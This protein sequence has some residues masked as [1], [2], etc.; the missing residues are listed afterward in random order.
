MRT[1]ASKTHIIVGFDKS[2]GA[3]AQALPTRINQFEDS[4]SRSK[5]NVNG[6][7]QPEQFN[8]SAVRSQ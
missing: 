3:P 7:Y 2:I 6:A 1:R 8:K 4:T 5:R